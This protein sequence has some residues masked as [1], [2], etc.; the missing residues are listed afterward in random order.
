MGMTMGQLGLRH[1]LARARGLELELARRRTKALA[2]LEARK[3]EVVQLDAE[4]VQVGIQVQQLQAAL[5]S[6]YADTSDDVEAR[7]TFP[8]KHLT[9]WGGLT[10]AILAVLRAANGDALLKSEIAVQ[11]QHELGLTFTP[12]EHHLFRRQL[13]RSLKNMCRS[14]YVE[15]FHDQ[16]T[17]KEGLW[18]LKASSE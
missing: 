9:A 16:K 3:A 2:E 10:R 11:L 5:S 8:K 18:C 1:A 13:Q 17:S 14:G 4:I 6:V 12:E 7:R 15:R